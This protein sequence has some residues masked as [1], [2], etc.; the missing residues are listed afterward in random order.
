VVK[1]LGES[2][3]PLN[4]VVAGQLQRSLQTHEVKKTNMSHENT[5]RAWK[6]PAY[7]NSL[8]ETDRASLAAHP[9]GMIELSDA[10]LGVVAGG[11]FPT[12]HRTCGDNCGTNLIYLC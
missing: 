1:P 8:S 6:D 12:W 7:R 10:D 9:A 4:E 5:I 3:M 2:S 11:F